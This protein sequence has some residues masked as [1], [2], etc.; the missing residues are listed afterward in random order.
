[1]L[2]LIGRK[3]GMTQVFD[4]KGV[5]TPVTVIKFDE[6][7][8]VSE[9][10]EDKDG[11]TACVLA[12]VD[13]KASRVTKP[14]TGQFPEGVTPKKYIREFRNFDGEYAVGQKMGIEIFEDMEL[15]DVI[16][17]TKG[18]GYQGVMKRHG[19]GGGR[20]THGSKFHR[21]NGSTGMAAYPSKVIK[22]TKMAG[23]MGADKKT[24]Q[25]LKVVRVDADRKV[26]L[27]R[28]AVPGTVDSM[29]IVR[30]ATKSR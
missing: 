4:E 26:L 18:K 15:V 27:V 11:Y 7:V 25:N 23:R 29:V 19:F 6:N 16:G 10:T 20:K 28:G 9:K 30:E 22:G 21:A 3:V 2:G 13:K 17:T 24:V 5:L 14:V 8:V 1:M 12:S